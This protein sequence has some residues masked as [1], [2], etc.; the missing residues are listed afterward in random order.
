MSLVRYWGCDICDKEIKNESGSKGLYFYS[1]Q[2]GD[3]RLA[4]VNE[5]EGKHL[6]A[7]CMKS[8]LRELQSWN[9]IEEN[10]KR[11]EEE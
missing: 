8:L 3:F 7:C 4:N 9:T 10:S 11:Y 6:C 1:L 2:P 5:T